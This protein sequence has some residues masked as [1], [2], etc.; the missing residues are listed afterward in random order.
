MLVQNKLIGYA[1]DK[2]PGSADRVP[3]REAMFCR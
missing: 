3:P 1:Q 2:I